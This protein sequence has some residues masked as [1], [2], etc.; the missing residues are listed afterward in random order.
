M[1]LH[2]YYPDEP[3]VLAEA[4]AAADAGF[5]V[6]VVA[7][8]RPGDPAVAESDG[9]RCIRL[10]IRH[11]RGAGAAAVL[12]EYVGFTFLAALKA[13][14]LAPRR[15]DVV[16]V[17]NP[18]DFLVAAA[19]VPRLLGARIIFDVHDLASDM[20]AMRFERLPGAGPADRMLRLV[21]RAAAR[22]SSAVLTVHE[23]Y[24][25]ELAARGVPLEKVTVVM[26]SL[27][28]RLLPPANASPEAPAGFR[29]VYHGTLTPHYGVALVVEAVGEL[30]ARVDDLRLDI[31]GEGDAVPELEER[32]SVLGIEE[33]VRISGKYLPQYEVLRAVQGATVG[34]IPN[35]PTRLNRYALSTK[36][37]EY[38]A[39]GIPVVAADLPTIRE[40]F[41]DDE[42]RYFRAGDAA[43][44]ADALADVESDPA[45]AGRRAAA[46][47]RRYEQYRWQHSRQA[48]LDV[49]RA[50]AR[51]SEAA[52][53]TGSESV[54]D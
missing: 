12:G 6:D 42:V 50:L 22:F 8:R 2:G 51:P 18:P 14:R 34:V 53:G 16:Q 7:L 21:E 4:S 9:V 3:R 45:S 25:R 19:L 30:H 17:H 36:L 44:L 33:I 32:A 38:V 15:Y 31:Y 48:Y 49:L 29:V 24:R 35:L 27:D 41:S 5:D 11:R 40:H 54:P 43:S 28:E 1:L 26:N 47:T 39:L 23:P 13:A 52:P 20:F 10:P 46:A 37:L